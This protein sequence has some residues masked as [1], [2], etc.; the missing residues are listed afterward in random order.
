MGLEPMTVDLKG[1]RSSNWANDA[2]DLQY[3]KVVRLSHIDVG[4]REID[5]AIV[6]L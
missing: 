6:C 2:H 1:Q 3:H 4:M 5:L